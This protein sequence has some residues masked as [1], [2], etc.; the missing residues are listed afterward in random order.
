MTLIQ[1]MISL[2]H[3]LRLKVIAK[4][5][6]PRSRRSCWRLLRCDGCQ[7]Y[8]FSKPIP[9]EVAA[10][11]NITG[12]TVAVPSRGMAKS[13]NSGCAGTSRTTCAQGA[14]AGYRSRA[15]KAAGARPARENFSARA[16]PSWISAP[17]RS[18]SQVA[19]Q[20]VDARQGDCC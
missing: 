14:R 17:R 13:S 11:E 19:A 5:S 12:L 8:L 3:S 2:A 10:A 15:G 1:T 9:G 18:W 4:A 16:R 6:R 7:G 20:K